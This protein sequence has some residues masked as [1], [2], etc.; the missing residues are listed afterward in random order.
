MLGPMGG[1]GGGQQPGSSTLERLSVCPP[2]LCAVCCL[3]RKR[4]WAGPEVRLPVPLCTQ[5]LGCPSAT[6]T[7]I[8]GPIPWPPNFPQQGQA[9]SPVP[10]GL[11]ATCDLPDACLHPRQVGVSKHDG[12]PDLWAEPLAPKLHPARAG[13]Q[14]SA[15]WA[16]CG[17]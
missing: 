11:C 13:G 10:R 12:H 7:P 6:G 16:L 1:L 5:R 9:V 4:S 2:S 3:L 8:C 17:L 14:P 15:T